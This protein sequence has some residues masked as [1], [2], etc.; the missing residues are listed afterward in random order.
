MLFRSLYWTGEQPKE[1]L[2]KSA[3][4]EQVPVEEIKVEARSLSP[5]EVGKAAVRPASP[6][7]T[8]KRYVRKLD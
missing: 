8:P 3:R 7:T 4:K 6:A 1:R 2:A 5:A